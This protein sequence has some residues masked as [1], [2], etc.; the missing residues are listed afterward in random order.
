MNLQEQISRMKS[1]IKKINEIDLSNTYI[2]TPKEKIKNSKTNIFSKSPTS[3][4]MDY[5]I[6]FLDTGKGMYQ[7]LF[8]N[9]MPDEF[10]NFIQQY[11]EE[12]QDEI[13]WFESV[14]ADKENTSLQL[15]S[16]DIGD[17]ICSTKDFY[18]KIIYEQ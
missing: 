1:M 7:V 4:F 11:D 2:N 6:S 3:E 12:I 15:W 10:Y 18:Y 17:Q 5:G 16:N 14:L 9:R 8:M 13:D